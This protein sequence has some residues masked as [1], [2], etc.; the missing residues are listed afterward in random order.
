ML[1]WLLFALMT[2][3]AALAVLW[4]LGRAPIKLAAGEA[5]L[6]VYRDQLA[7]IERDRA[8]GLLTESDTDAARLEVSRRLIAAAD[9]AERESPAAASLFRR[10]LAAVAAIGGLPALALGLYLA[11][12]S[13]GLPGAPLAARL[14]KPPEQQDIALMV[15]R[16]EAHLAQDPKDGRGWELLA[17]IYLR[18][19]RAADAVKARTNARL[20]LGPSAEREAGLGEALVVEA[21]GVVTAAARAAFERA[22]RHE[23]NNP[24]ALFF[25]GLAAEQDG[26]AS[27]AV[28]LWR[29][30]SETAAPDDPWRAAAARRIAR[31]EAGR[32]GGAR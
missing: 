3:A 23:R 8:R 24:K 22:R 7:E 26:R 20:L 13:P 25:L 30:L 18:M 12:G 4:P 2:A 14:A 31:L 29:D 32:G 9:A 5:D 21:D 16:I 28:S 17:P 15:R 27:D 19:G 10:R 6:A 1:F 11:L